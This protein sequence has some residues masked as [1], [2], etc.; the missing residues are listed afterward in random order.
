MYFTLENLIMSK[1]PLNLGFMLDWDEASMFHLI[2]LLENSSLIDMAKKYLPRP[3]NSPVSLPDDDDEF[4]ELALSRKDT[5]VVEPSTLEF[6]FE[7]KCCF[8]HL[9]NTL[10]DLKYGTSP[11]IL[12]LFIP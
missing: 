12:D 6:L 2:F 7:T 9:Y 1:I 5:S 10:E 3:N 4:W 8:P 11:Q